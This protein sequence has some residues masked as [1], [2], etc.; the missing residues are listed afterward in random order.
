M[1]GA[2]SAEGIRARVGSRIKSPCSVQN[3]MRRRGVSLAELHDVCGVRI[4]VGDVP[5]CYQALQTT[6]RLWPHLPAAFDDYIV[7]PKRNGYQSLHTVVRLPCGHTLEVQIRTTTQHH[8]AETGKAAHW[9]Y[10]QDNG[11]AWPPGSW[12]TRRG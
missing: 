3:K 4:V 8:R 6:H 9:R 5:T 11:G 1:S 2:L 7:S 10:K 12:E